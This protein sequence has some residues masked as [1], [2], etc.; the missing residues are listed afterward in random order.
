MSW[1]KSLGDFCIDMLMI[2]AG[3]SLIMILFFEFVGGE[4]K[5]PTLYG[6][7]ALIFSAIVICLFRRDRE[8]KD[9]N[10]TYSNTQNC[11]I[12]KRVFD[13]YDLPDILMRYDFAIIETRD[14]DGEFK[15]LI[16]VRDPNHFM[17][18]AQKF[19]WTINDPLKKDFVLVVDGHDFNRIADM[20]SREIRDTLISTTIG[21]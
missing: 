5:L 20:I 10:S 9:K 19:D 14:L 18:L 2:F 13:K 15:T 3:G 6:A 8:L 21:I 16:Y 4:M 12:I 7:L 1:Q 11:Y 17:R